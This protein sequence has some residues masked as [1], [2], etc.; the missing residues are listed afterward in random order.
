MIRLTAIAPNTLWVP[1]LWPDEDD[2]RGTFTTNSYFPNIRFPSW[3]RNG[4]DWMNQGW[5]W[6]YQ[7]RPTIDLNARMQ[8]GPNASCPPAL[9]PLTN[10]RTPL[11]T[12]VAN[13]RTYGSGGTNTAEGLAWAWRAISPGAPFDEGRPYTDRE[14]RKIIVL[15]TDGANFVST[16]ST[17]TTEPTTGP[18]GICRGNGWVQTTGHGRA[19]SLTRRLLPCAGPSNSAR[20]LSTQ[21]CLILRNCRQVFANSWRL[22]LHHAKP[23]STMFATR[24]G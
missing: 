10:N 21:S 7:A 8:Q 2:R 12:L 14:N 11:D 18:M 6:K 3:V 9:M 15:M 24:P 19:R 20:S 17:V 1:Y 13:L 5:V 22:A 16:Q 4:S 23:T